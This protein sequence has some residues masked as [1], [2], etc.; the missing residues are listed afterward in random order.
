[1]FRVRVR[2]IYSTA[3]TKLF[4]DEN[5]EIVQPSHMIEERFDL[6]SSLKPYD[7]DIYDRVDKQGVNVLCL[8]EIK[9]SLISIFHNNL[10]DAVIRCWRPHV[11]GVYK[12]V[13]REVDRTR[14]KCYVEIEPGVFGVLSLR[15]LSFSVEDEVI[16][17]VDRER[18]G[19]RYP[20]LS[21]DVKV[22][23]NYAILIP[24]ETVKISR[25]IRD[26]DKRLFLMRI[27]HEL[28]PRGWGI[29]WRTA[30]LSVSEDKLRKE[31]SKL[32][33]KCRLF[34]SKASGVD[35][36]VLL[37]EGQIFLDIELPSGSKKT[38]DEIRSLITPTVPG[39][40]YLKSFNIEL[41][42]SV[43][44]AESLLERGSS[45]EEIVN[46]LNH[47]LLVSLPEEGDM[48]SIKHV[49]LNGKTISIGPAK[50]EVFDPS[51][52]IIK[53]RR[54]IISPGLYD[55]IKVRKSPGDYAITETKVGEWYL[56][57]RYFSSGNEFKGAYINVN[58][59]VEVYS[60]FIRYVDLEVDVCVDYRGC[61]SVLDKDKLLK[62]VEM[63]VVS[64]DLSKRVDEV[65]NHILEVRVPI[66]L[67]EESPCW[68]Y[69][70][71]SSELA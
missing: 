70:H 36:P 41:S 50:I 39:H 52:G 64:K 18:L 22:L 68:S 35:G 71:D 28:R 57:T 47:L 53:V 21:R 2:G 6:T 49:K 40:H 13:V 34:I 48:I 16:V 33:D 20:S 12:G 8:P 37:M 61:V 4:L 58:T 25:K 17:Q 43:D 54:R 38:L 46:K 27:G 42:T 14:G 55:G 67:G 19:V 23:G 24:R 29:I 3:L 66:I 9:S 56:E 5:Y 10:L 1:M 59:P 15:G 32:L 60:N 65:I 45:F 63:K 69:K 11:G 7:V 62:A 31:I 44:M 30:A 51:L 26:P